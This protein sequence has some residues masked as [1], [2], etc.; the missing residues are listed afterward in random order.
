MKHI[1]QLII[2]IS[3]F[4]TSSFSFA[5]YTPE[6]SL[7]ELVKISP[8]IVRGKVVDVNPYAYDTTRNL[9][10]TMISIKVMETIKGYLEKGETFEIVLIG[11]FSPKGTFGFV[12]GV[13]NLSVVY[14]LG[15]L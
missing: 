13:R 4:I 10:F 11:G 6:Y 5:D 2:I 9:S 3:L 12:A 7:H 1:T 14:K 15:S 8:N